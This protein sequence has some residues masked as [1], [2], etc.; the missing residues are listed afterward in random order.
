MNLLQHLRE[1]KIVPVVDIAS[2]LDAVPVARALLDA[3]LPSVEITFRTAVAAEA[4]KAVAAELP[5]VVVGAGTVRTPE[6]VDRAV[7]AGAVFLVAPGLNE[8]VISRA[9]R[10]GVPVLPGVCTPTEVEQALSMDLRLLKFFPAE[11]A[12][13]AAYLSALAGPYPDVLFV[14]TGGI[15]PSNLLAYLTKANVVACGGSWMVKRDLIA[16]GDFAAIS[17]LTAEAL[18]IAESTEEE[19]AR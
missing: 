18:R 12:G 19:L 2:V 5:E 4:I 10:L 3:G 6:Q 13:G 14:P 7:D 15:G 1:T 16:S 9:A 8:A 17:R 11:V